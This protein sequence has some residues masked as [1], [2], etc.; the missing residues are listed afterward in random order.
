LRVRVGIATGLVVVGDLG[1][2]GAAPEHDVVGET[3][4]TQK[5]AQLS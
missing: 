5:A 1:G 2:E 3:P 4:L